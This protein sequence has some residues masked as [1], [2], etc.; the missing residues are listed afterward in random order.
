MTRQQRYLLLAM[1][2]VD[3]VVDH[4]RA[5]A[6]RRD[7]YKNLCHDFP[8]M[9]MTDGL[10]QTLAFVEAKAATA[11]TPVTGQAAA[12]RD[13]QANVREILDIGAH[14]LD[15]IRSEP[16]VAYMRHTQ[17]VL[18]AWVYFKRF[19]DAKMPQPTELTR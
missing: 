16:L 2:A 14:P 7:T 15:T 10:C 18:E 1:N 11:A 12:Y 3:I 13:L 5:D 19:A 4:A 8:V 17:A 9:V 6:A